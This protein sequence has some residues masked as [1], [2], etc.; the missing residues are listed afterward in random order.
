MN[1]LNRIIF[2]NS[3]GVDFYELQLDGNIHFIGTQGTGKS[4]LLRAILFFYNADARK[5][6]ISKEKKSFSEYYF[7]YADSYIVYEVVQDNRRFC[8]WLYKKQNRLGF[9]FIDGPYDR[10]LFINKQHALQEK[11]VIEN[12]S[13][14]GYKVHRHI[15]NFTEYRDIIYGANR[16]MNRFHLLQNTAYQNIPRT[17]SNIFLNSS[18][19][20]GFIKT[21][22]I[23]SLSD[24][25]FEINLDAN[26]HHIE[27]ARNDYRDVS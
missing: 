14:K 17:I 1:Q 22:I 27:T 7:P 25:S 11:E 24:E 21:T 9:R 8:V 20:G 2:I 16:S 18:L 6:G 26:R 15:Y 4:T 10:T 13:Q 12:A 5:L 23:N 3:A 19:D